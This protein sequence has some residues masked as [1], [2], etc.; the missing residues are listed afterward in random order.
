[1][2]TDVPEHEAAFD[3]SIDPDNTPADDA[4]EAT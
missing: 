3:C 2:A 4:A 1:M